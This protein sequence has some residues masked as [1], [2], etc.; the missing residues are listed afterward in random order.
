MPTGLAKLFLVY[1]SSFRTHLSGLD[2][3]QLDWVSSAAADGAAPIEKDVHKTNLRFPA[4]L[5]EYD[6]KL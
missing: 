2:A 4:A 5:I 3:A 6:A 1:H